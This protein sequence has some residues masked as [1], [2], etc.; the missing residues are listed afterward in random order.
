L[1][2]S[3]IKP[4]LMI[5]MVSFFYFNLNCWLGE[6]NKGK[7]TVIYPD[8]DDCKLVMKRIVSGKLWKIPIII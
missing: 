3:P 8:P 6:G 4:Q 7:R 5:E 1:V 2:S